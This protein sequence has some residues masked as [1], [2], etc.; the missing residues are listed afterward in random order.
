MPDNPNPRDYVRAMDA[1]LARHMSDLWLLHLREGVQR[2]QLP[3]P[4]PAPRPA[5]LPAASARFTHEDRNARLA[6]IEVSAEARAFLLVGHHQ[7]RL[8]PQALSE[9]FGILRV[10]YHLP[11]SH[12]SI[13]LISRDALLADPSVPNDESVLGLPESGPHAAALAITIH[14]EEESAY[15]ALPHRILMASAV[16]HQLDPNNSQEPVIH[17]HPAS[18][19]HARHYLARHPAGQTIPEPLR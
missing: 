9:T 4:L 19:H 16:W 3:Y 17:A 5:H 11:I 8:L 18:L 1:D 15:A 6:R 2:H 13:D 14:H 10:D 12:L 7:A